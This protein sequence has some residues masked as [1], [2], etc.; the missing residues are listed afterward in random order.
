[1][2]PFAE[3]AVSALSCGHKIAFGLCGDAGTLPEMT[4]QK[5]AT[6]ADAYG[7]FWAA[8]PEFRPKRILEIGVGR[9]GSLALWAELFDG[10]SVV[11]VDNNLDQLMPWTKAHF[12]ETDRISVRYFQ[13]PD[14]TIASLGTFDLIIDDGGHGPKAVFP[15]FEICWPML[16]PGGTYIIEDWRQDFLSPEAL[17]SFAARKLLGDGQAPFTPADAP[18]QIVANRGFIALEKKR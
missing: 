14:P 2:K 7:P 15:A 6:V 1:M 5:D 11:G 10:A 17:I 16:E 3:V 13:M 4:H 12:A 18:A 8:R 9:G